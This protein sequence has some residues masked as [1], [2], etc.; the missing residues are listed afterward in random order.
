M[1][2]H[3]SRTKIVP[4]LY[5]TSLIQC[6][7]GLKTN[8]IISRYWERMRRMQLL[9]IMLFKI[10]L[11]KQYRTEKGSKLLTK[12]QTYAGI[13]YYQ[14]AL[15]VNKQIKPMVL[16]ADC[17]AADMSRVVRE[18][19]FLACDWSAV[20]YHMISFVGTDFLTISEYECVITTLKQYP[21]L[22]VVV[23]EENTFNMPGV[24]Q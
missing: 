8:G 9:Q 14:F 3:N 13:D 15:L 2:A 5:F 22:I 11:T 23:C 7:L 4:K 20:S 19:N 6:N 17:L 24:I 16:F 10:T 21:D 18:V 1:Y 12:M